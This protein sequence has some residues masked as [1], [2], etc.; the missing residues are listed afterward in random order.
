M[1]TK[2]AQPE[3]RITYVGNEAAGILAE[4]DGLEPPW[5][6]TARVLRDGH[7]GPERER[8]TGLVIAEWDQEI[9]R[10]WVIGPWVVGDGKAWMATASSLVDAALAQ[11]PPTV[12]RHEMAGEVAHHRLAALAAARGWTG[13]EP[14]HILV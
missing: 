5:L 14:N 8:I 3:R 12:T 6:S 1:A 13:S 7:G 10:A 11:L 2:Q 4:L 9:G